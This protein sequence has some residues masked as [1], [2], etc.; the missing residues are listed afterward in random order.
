MLLLAWVAVIRPLNAPD[1]PAH[2]QAV[3]TVRRAHQLPAIHFVFSAPD[4][5]HGA[6]LPG[7]GDAGVQAYTAGLRRGDYVR[8]PY[9]SM[10]APL[11]YLAAGLVAQVVPPDPPIVLYV[12]RLV[13]ALFGAGTVFFVWAAVREIAPD[14]PGWALAAAACVALLPQFGFNSATASNDSA[15]NCLTAAAFWTWLRGLRDPAFDPRGVGAG[16]AFGGALLAKLTGAA[17][18]PALALALLFR[19]WHEVPPTA[20]LGARLARLA[21]LAGGAALGAAVVAGWWLVRNW[22]VYGDPTGSRDAFRF[23]HGRF[24]Q[25]DFFDPASRAQ[26]FQWTWESFWGRFGWMSLRLPEPWYWGAGALLLGTA[27]L[28]GAAVVRRVR[29]ARAGGPPIAPFAWQVAAI[30]G[31]ASLGLVASFVE[32]NLGVNIQPQ[33]RYLFGL[34]LPWAL[35]LTGGL[36]ALPRTPRGRAL[37]AERAG[38]R[39][40]RRRGGQP[41]DGGAGAVGG[42]GRGFASGASRSAGSYGARGRLCP[43]LSIAPAGNKRRRRRWTAGARGGWGAGGCHRAGPAGRRW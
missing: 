9:E 34:L 14:L 6:P 11:Y 28:S 33:G 2:L 22:F 43:I 8:I 40:R 35:V 13:A 5:D 4:S 21:R 19:A 10:Q 15:F 23:Y 16:L 12:S 32:F 38:A 39:A 29:A 31:L 1:E 36:A 7:Q 42:R 27:A 26:F 37:G 24:Q 30:L 20:G 18:A 25:L 17:L 41:G 3:M